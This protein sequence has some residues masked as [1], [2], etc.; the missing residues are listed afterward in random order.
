MQLPF[1][2]F[3]LLIPCYNNTAGLLRS[4]ASVQYPRE[5]RILVVDDG[6]EVPVHTAL[7]AMN[8]GHLHVLT[9]PVNRGI[10]AALNAGL[11]WIGENL[12]PRY[13]ARLDCGDTC[14][15]QRF[16]RQ[17]ELM[18]SDLS[19][20]ITGTWCRFLRADGVGFG[21]RTP[22]FHEDII[23]EMYGRNVFIHPAV[24]MRTPVLAEAGG[25]PEGFETVEDY[26]LFWRML[27]LS[28]GAVIPEFLV[29]AEITGGGISLR[30]R[31]KQ[32]RARARVIRKFG[33]RVPAQVGGYSRL[34]LLFIL[35]KWL[36]LWIKRRKR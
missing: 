33:T 5:Y 13:I 30:N 19:L 18:D 4:L 35:P 25:Y 28:R 8:T 24:M 16:L 32:L 29:T 21:Y 10:T 23:K 22:V 36:N 2:D 14:H 12:R 1:I 26:A 31:G 7:N 17:V 20:G 6:S 34:L 3:C 27:Q 15:P 11:R 9:L